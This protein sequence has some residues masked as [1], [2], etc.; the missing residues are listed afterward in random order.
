MVLSLFHSPWLLVAS[1]YRLQQRL[2]P[3]PRSSPL[4]LQE[5]VWLNQGGER[6]V[7]KKQTKKRAPDPDEPP[8][9]PQ[10]IDRRL[11]LMGVLA[12]PAIFSA[13][14]MS[15]GSGS[16]KKTSQVNS[17]GDNMD[18]DAVTSPA[19]EIQLLEAIELYPN[20]QP[21]DFTNPQ[22]AAA[23]TLVP[24]LEARGGSQV[25]ASSMAG[26]WVLPWVGGW[27]RVWT[28]TADTRPF[29]GPQDLQFKVGAK[30]YT[31]L[32]AR[33]FVYGPGEGG[34]IVE[35]LYGERDAA[36][37]IGQKLLLT[38]PGYVSNLG[39][40]TFQLAFKGPLDEYE[41]VFNPK[42]NQD[43]LRTGEKLPGGS[44]AS[45]AADDLFLRTTYLSERLWIIRDIRDPSIVSVFE[46]TNTYS[47]FDRRGLVME[48][49]LKPSDN[50]QVRYGALLFGDTKEDYQG[51]AEKAAQADETKNKLLGR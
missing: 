11:L 47:V 39:D 43:G 5:R 29:G 42:M 14:S 41:V 48:K 28:S 38:R 31:Q 23:Y 27:D 51:W 36:G 25:K 49:Q 26:R 4:F 33:Q 37:S 34:A 13:I 16:S 3:S 8:E 44:I 2:V 17:L 30:T 22:Y 45:Q 7:A 15:R 32:A 20:A 10:G 40:N 1:S 6:V 35:F 50:E 46:R 19:L 24:Q 9:T 12:Q 21:G 18:G